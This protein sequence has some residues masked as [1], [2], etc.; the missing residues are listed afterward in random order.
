MPGLLPIS[1][2]PRSR[3][4]GFSFTEVLFA[5][6][7][8]GIGFIMIAAVFPV[9]IQQNQATLQ[10]TTAQAVAADA[11]NQLRNLSASS[12]GV[13]FPPTSTGYP[14]LAFT[15]PPLNIQAAVFPPLAALPD[16]EAI[17]VPAWAY[18]Y[19]FNFINSSDPR[20][21]W[22]AFYRRNAG[23]QSARFII[24]VLKNQNSTAGLTGFTAGDTYPY[25]GA[26]LSQTNQNYYGPPVVPGTL[27]NLPSGTSITPT[28]SVPF[29]PPM[30][31]ASVAYNADGTSSI[32]MGAVDST[33]KAVP[34]PYRTVDWAAPGAFVVVAADSVAAKNSA[35]DMSGRV[36]RLGRQLASTDPDA[37]QFNTTLDPSQ[38]TMFQLVPGYD[39]RQD[40]SEFR[41][42]TVGT[43][44]TGGLLVYVVGTP[45]PIAPI[46]YSLNTGIGVMVPPVGPSAAAAQDIAVFYATIPVR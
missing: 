42:T 4:R 16:Y 15:N 24:L 46:Q 7:L 37:S 29:V 19:N 5:V 26:A 43:N 38:Q 39:L 28:N 31:V 14:V 22:V 12:P 17:N 25:T 9:A 8:L 11:I 21:A 32:A 36:F 23:E 34:G 20:F 3:H 44:F 1:S 13:V 10:E 27:F 18:N 45:L 40:Q 30:T 35:A 41:S 6:M 33:G 2:S